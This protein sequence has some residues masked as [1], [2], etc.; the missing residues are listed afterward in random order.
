MGDFRT[1]FVGGMVINWAWEQYLRVRTGWALQNDTIPTALK[2]HI[3]AKT[4]DKTRRYNKMKNTFGFIDD[5]VGVT[6]QLGML[7]V[8]PELWNVAGAAVSDRFGV[9]TDS[10]YRQYIQAMLFLTMG[11]VVEWPVSLVLKI[12]RTFV[13]EEEFGFNKHTWKS[14]ASDEIKSLVV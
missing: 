5:A 14:F 7:M 13:I 2:A 12:Y 11:S 4:F 9:E 6:L 1:L 10:A 3:D 8:S